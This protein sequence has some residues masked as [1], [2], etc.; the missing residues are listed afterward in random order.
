MKRILLS[1]LV[2][3]MMLSLSAANFNAQENVITIG[4]V[5][6]QYEDGAWPVDRLLSILER[7]MELLPPPDAYNRGTSLPQPPRNEPAVVLS[8]R[9][10]LRFAAQ[11]DKNLCASA[12]RGR[13]RPRSPPR[14]SGGS[15]RANDPIP[16]NGAFRAPR[17]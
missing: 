15:W 7:D 8:L 4:L 11:R 3:G 14:P 5:T 17:W 10:R 1:L 16:T 9:C 2:V 12:R 6:Y 13:L